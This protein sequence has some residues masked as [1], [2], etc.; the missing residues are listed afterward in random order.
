MMIIK[1]RAT[2]IHKGFVQD[3][4]SRLLK[5]TDVQVSDTLEASLG[6]LHTWYEGLTREVVVTLCCLGT[7]DRKI[8]CV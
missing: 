3:I 6:D 7:D 2:K 8:T 5:Y 4:P 1:K